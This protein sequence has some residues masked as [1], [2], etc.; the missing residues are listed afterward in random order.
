MDFE[1]G[2]IPWYYT[3][4]VILQL[5]VHTNRHE[6]SEVKR[7]LIARPNDLEREIKEKEEEGKRLL[8]RGDVDKGPSGRPSVRLVASLRDEEE[9]EGD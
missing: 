7:L 5:I 8:C 4:G 1:G 6:W 3:T 9:E 2:I